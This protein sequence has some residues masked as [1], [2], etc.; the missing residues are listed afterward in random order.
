MSSHETFL[1][2]IL[3]HPE[4]DA[5][6]LVYADWLEERGDPRGEFIRVQYDL[7]DTKGDSARQKRLHIRELELLARHG[8]EWGWPFVEMKA[9]PVYRRGFVEGLRLDAVTFLANA[10]KIFHA[11]P[12]RF[13]QFREA[14]EAP[15]LDLLDSPFLAHLTGLD[16]HGNFI[17][18]M[19]AHHLAEC[20]HLKGLKELLLS[21]CH[22]E[23]D[24][25]RALAASEYLQVERLDLSNNPIG[26]LGVQ[27][28][29]SGVHPNLHT[30]EVASCGIGAAALR[31]LMR[32]KG[33]GPRFG[34]DLRALDVSGNEIGHAGLRVL[35]PSPQLARLH[36][37]R[38]ANAN[39]DSL[40]VRTLASSPN[41]KNLTELNLSANHISPGGVIAL[42]ESAQMSQL[43]DLYLMGNP[44]PEGERAALKK[45]FR[46]TVHL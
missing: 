17:G 3:S 37:L 4:D 13:V 30:L 32:A 40:G 7:A 5:L 41:V 26:D 33:R 12:V 44:I 18:D 11:A 9:S 6:R 21:H 28:I 36:S 42:A 22:I 10:E 19:A 2:A 46:C 14:G 35:A 16:L 38:I 29:G 24:G 34:L 15:L 43:T 23:L 31:E 25:V 45:R 27:A 20:E 8:D 1:E 39:I